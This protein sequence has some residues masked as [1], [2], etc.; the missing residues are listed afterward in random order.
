MILKQTI[1]EV[2]GYYVKN[3]DSN[4]QLNPA[5]WKILQSQYSVLSTEM[6]TFLNR[7]LNKW[8]IYLLI[9][10]LKTLIDNSDRLTRPVKVCNRD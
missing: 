6:S 4:W 2:Y 8:L 3:K 10:L 7:I 9:K 5:L 1:Y